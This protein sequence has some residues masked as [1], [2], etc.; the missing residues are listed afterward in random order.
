MRSKSKSLLSLSRKIT[1]RPDQYRVYYQNLPLGFDFINELCLP[2]KN[3]KFGFPSLCCIL[4]IVSY[5]TISGEGITRFN[6]PKVLESLQDFILIGYK[7]DDVIFF[8]LSLK[9]SGDEVI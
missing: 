7:V 2:R 5:C 4:H 8:G 9:L 1:M 3:C 6:L